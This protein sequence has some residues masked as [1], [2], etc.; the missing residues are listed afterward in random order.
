MEFTDYQ[1]AVD[2]WMTLTDDV[3]TAEREER[4]ARKAAEGAAKEQRRKRK[5]ASRA[6]ARAALQQERDQSERDREMMMTRRSHRRQEESDSED[7]YYSCSPPEDEFPEESE[8]VNSGG[9]KEFEQH[10]ESLSPA[11]QALQRGRQRNSSPGTSQV[12]SQG[13][14]SDPPAVASQTPL[15]ATTRCQKK[16]RRTQQRLDEGFHDMFQS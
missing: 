9:S 6:A 8:S 11:S 13:L 2:E 5:E 15:R 4:A 3:E 14:A 7:E 1:Q 10:E 12:M 16:R